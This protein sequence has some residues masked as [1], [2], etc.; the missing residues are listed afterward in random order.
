[1][2]SIVIPVKDGGEALG[3]CLRAISRQQLEHEE[4]V[5]LVVVD[6]GSRDGS[7]QLA[8]DHGARVREIA[9]REFSHG[10]ARNLGASLSRGELLVF[11]SQ[12]ATPVNEYWLQRLTRPLREEALLAGVYGRQVANDDATPPERYFLDFLYGPRPRRQR[13]ARVSELSMV[14]TLFSNVNGAIRRELW[15]RFPFVEDIVMSED[16]DWSRRVLL[17]GWSICYEPAAAVRHSHTYTIASAFRR[18]FDSGASADRAYLAGEGHSEWV[19][20]AAALRYAR[21]EIGWL[22]RSGQARWIPYTVVYEL[23]KLA[24]LLLGARHERLPQ[25]LKRRLS[26]MPGHWQELTARRVR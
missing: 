1:V 3:R 13:A 9:P 12:D 10:A 20:R 25:P 24:G 26:A 23:A 15:E 6:S 21:G 18:F 19:L 14:T 16:Q 4:P 22:L 7:V 8:L 11:I 5:E 17:E 2:I